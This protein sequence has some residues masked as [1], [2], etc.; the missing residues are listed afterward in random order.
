[1]VFPAL[2][3]AGLWQRNFNKEHVQSEKQEDRSKGKQS[4][5]NSQSF[6]TKRSQALWLLPRPA[7][8]TPGQ[9]LRAVL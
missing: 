2:C 9:G 8:H 7:E 4:G 1:M 5:L 3:S 6:T